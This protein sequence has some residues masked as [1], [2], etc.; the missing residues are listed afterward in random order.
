MR[1][2][3]TIFKKIAIILAVFSFIGGPLSGVATYANL[4]IT[5]SFF[6]DW[7]LSFLKSICVML[8]AAWVLMIIVD[9]ISDACLGTL[10][11]LPRNLISGFIFGILMQCVVT[12]VT[13]GSNVGIDPPT[14]FF[15][16]WA[17]GFA[18][19]LPL[20]L[21]ISVVMTTLIRPRLER[22]MAS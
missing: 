5:D 9:R 7:G 8:P 6:S 2:V 20:G 11:R 22:I 15:R 4:G 19:A 3:Q 10:K 14:V 18:T 16:A 12:A 21:L 17:T 13:A 1:K